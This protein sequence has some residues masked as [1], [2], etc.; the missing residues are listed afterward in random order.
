MPMFVAWLYR[1]IPIIV[2]LMVLGFI[3]YMV[4]YNTR[5]AQPAKDAFTRIFW[6]VCLVGTVAFLIV[7]LYAWGESNTNLAEFFFICSVT[8]A[9][10]WGVDTLFG[11]LMRRRDRGRRIANMARPPKDDT[12]YDE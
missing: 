5:G 4:L 11:Y 7:A 10:F 9:F 6:W 1:A 3:I 12:I 2:G 8:M